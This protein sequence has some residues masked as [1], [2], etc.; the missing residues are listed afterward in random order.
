[1]SVPRYIAVD[2][3]KTVGFSF[4][5]TEGKHLQ[6]GQLNY[7]VFKKMSAA[8]VHGIM[9]SNP[10]SKLTLIV[11]NFLLLPHMALKMSS[12][13]SRE[14]H[15]SQ[16]IGSMHMLA[17]ITKAEIVIQST[18]ALGTGAAWARIDVEG[19]GHSKSHWK[20]AYAHGTYYMVTNKIRTVKDIRT[21]VAPSL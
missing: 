5:D 18:E 14:L 17:E 11:E 10:D 21:D 16:V 4:F 3:G 20:S 13:H 15:A 12:T 6:S 2:P 1:V 8:L 9:S 19:E 7:E